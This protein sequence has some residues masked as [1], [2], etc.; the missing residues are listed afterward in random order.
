[1]RLDEGY[2]CVYSAWIHL[3][4]SDLKVALSITLF[5]QQESL[6][7][8][9]VTMFRPFYQAYQQWTSV[10]LHFIIITSALQKNMVTVVK[11]NLFQD[12]IGAARNDNLEIVQYIL[13]HQKGDVNTRESDKV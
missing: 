7:G 10:S 9:R 1:M 12:L 11:Y 6:G 13:E 8:A 2:S 3:L 5:A 4:L